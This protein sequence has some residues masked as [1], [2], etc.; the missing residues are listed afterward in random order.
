[1]LSSRPGSEADPVLRALLRYTGTAVRSRSEVCAY[2]AR[3]RVPAGTQQALLARCRAQGLIDD[4][5]AARLWAGYWARQGFA[6]AAI[7][8]RLTTRGFDVRTIQHA[9][10]LLGRASADEA[11]ARV[12]A[13]RLGRTRPSRAR[14]ARALTARGFDA[15][16]IERVLGSDDPAD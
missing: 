9:C 8:E 13:A 15:D 6:A 11:R 7:R 3:R 2:L 4:R 5:A 1:M 12:V 10:A 16:V 14:L